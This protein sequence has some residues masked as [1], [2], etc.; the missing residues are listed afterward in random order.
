MKEGLAM[1][2]VDRY[3]EKPTV[4]NETLEVFEHW[5]HRASL[6]GDESLRVGDHDAIVY[7]YVRG[8]WLL[9]YIED[10]RPEL[11]KG[12][13]SR[14]YHHNDLESRIA[15]AYGKKHEEFW[16]EIDRVLV[17]HFKQKGG[18]A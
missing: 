2:T 12:L 6:G 14:L 18:A 8:Y 17:S 11:L 16:C 7:Q 1:V 5:S 10:T 9:R 4:Q 13:L 3:F 15:T